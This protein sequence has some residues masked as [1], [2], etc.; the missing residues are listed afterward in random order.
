MYKSNFSQY[1]T[2]AQSIKSATAVRKGIANE[3]TEAQYN[4]MVLVHNHIY[5]PFIEHFHRVIPVSSFFRSEKLN[6]AIG[7][8]KTSQHKSGQ[9]ID[10]DCD[11]LGLGLTNKMLFDWGIK[12]LDFD[13]AILEAPDE[14]NNPSWCHF[15]YVSKDK[16]RKEVL[17]MIKKNGKTIYEHI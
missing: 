3:P 7:G 14:H 13:Q 5:L 16:N 17:R 9:A 11:G 12:N 1:L 6:T 10:L 4:N 8:S 15:S 2:Y